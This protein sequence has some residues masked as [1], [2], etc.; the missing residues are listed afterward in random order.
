MPVQR[1]AIVAALSALFAAPT[2]F[3]ADKL[4]AALTGGEEVPIVSTAAA[5]EFAGLISG[6]G[7]AIDYE[8][9]FNGLQGAVQQAHIHLAQPS[10][11]GAIVIWLCQTPTTQAPLA[12]RDLTPECPQSGSVRGLITQANVLA[13]ATQQVAAGGIGQVVAAMR[14]G[15]AYVNVH[16]T[17]SLGGEIRGQVR[18]DQRS[19]AN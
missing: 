11:N 1:I 4:R 8:L 13:I 18:A 16:T 9:S 2:A 7:D 14:A 10:V 12:V 17:P 19:A 6:G 3:A 15:F 5:G